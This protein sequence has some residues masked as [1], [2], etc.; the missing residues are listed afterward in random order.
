[1]FWIVLGILEF[2]LVTFFG[3]SMKFFCPKFGFFSSAERL[4]TRIVQCIVLVIS[5]LY[6]PLDLSWSWRLKFGEKWN[7]SV[8]N[9][10]KEKVVIVHGV[11]PER[12][13]R[14]NGM[15]HTER[16]TPVHS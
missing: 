14:I 11:V 2:W 7:N 10:D 12:S 9:G 3:E 13:I 15:W 8:F 6:M 1:M 5:T 16:T 4:W